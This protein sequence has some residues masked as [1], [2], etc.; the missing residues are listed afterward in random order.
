MTLLGQS[1]I[2]LDHG[3]ALQIVPGRFVER[4]GRANVDAIFRFEGVDRRLAVA[5]KV[6]LVDIWHV[7][8]VG[9]GRAVDAIGSQIEQ[10]AGLGHAEL[11]APR[12][13]NSRSIPGSRSCRPCRPTG[14]R[15]ARR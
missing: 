8:A 10:F 14:N 12:A 6:D 4:V 9:A 7:P 11:A 15:D 1:A 13:R 3:L 2:Q 5:V